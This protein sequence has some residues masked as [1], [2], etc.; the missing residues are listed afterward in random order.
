[1]TDTQRGTLPIG[2]AVASLLRDGM[3]VRFTAYDG[4][5]GRAPGRRHRPG[6]DEPAWPGLPAHRPR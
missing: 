2:D 4:S 5:V 1:M 6:A 3:P